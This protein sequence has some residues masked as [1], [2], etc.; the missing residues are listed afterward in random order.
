[1][2][3]T[4]RLTEAL[5]IEAG[6]AETILGIMRGTIDPFTVPA[7]EAWRQACYHEPDARKP[8]TR[9]HAIDALLGTHGTEALWG[10]DSCTIPA[11]EY[12]NNGDT[13]ALTI[14]YDYVKGC[15]R[16]TSWGDFVERFERRYGLQ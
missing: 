15:Y 4:A 14:L 16:L 3:T 5:G 1:M 6:T 8:E 9:M 13:Y 11:A 2:L 12:C 10:K 7:T